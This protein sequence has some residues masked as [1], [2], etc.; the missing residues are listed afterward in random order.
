MARVGPLG[1]RSA[2]VRR[3]AEVRVEVPGDPIED[4]VLPR[5][6]GAVITVSFGRAPT[7]VRSFD[8]TENGICRLESNDSTVVIVK[9]GRGIVPSVAYPPIPPWTA[10][11][12]KRRLHLNPLTA[13][14]ELCL[15][16]PSAVTSG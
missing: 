2:L 5:R 15:F 6:H 9:N 10:G 7:G 13:G 8:G 11:L 16:A 4:L 1:V 12:L 14:G 3:D